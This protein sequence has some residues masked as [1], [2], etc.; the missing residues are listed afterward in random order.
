MTK[1]HI[2]VHQTVQQQQQQQQPQWDYNATF[3]LHDL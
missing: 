3:G 1:M 2:D